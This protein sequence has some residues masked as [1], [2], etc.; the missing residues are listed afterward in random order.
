MTTKTAKPKALKP[1]TQLQQAIDTL[2]AIQCDLKFECKV[3][4]Q[5][6]REDRTSLNDKNESYSDLAGS[7]LELEAR[8]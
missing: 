4:T 6:I 2:Y 1:D 7:I 5:R 8:R 3:L